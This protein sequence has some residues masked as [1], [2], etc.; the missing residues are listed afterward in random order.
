VSL[1]R[2]VPTFLSLGARKRLLAQKPWMCNIATAFSHPAQSP[3]SAAG[4][5]IRAFP[6]QGLFHTLSEAY[7][8]I[9]W[10]LASVLRTFKLQW[11]G[12]ERSF[13]GLS[14]QLLTMI[15]AQERRLTEIEQEL[16][17]LKCRTQEAA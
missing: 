4:P 6:S 16:Q 7:L 3:Q 14:E 5:A 8:A 11:K 1:C 12:Y 9:A 15:T 17:R 2:R 13:A 10:V